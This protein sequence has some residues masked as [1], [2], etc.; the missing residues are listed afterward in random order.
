MT[1]S[2]EP[3]A[4]TAASAAGGGIADGSIADAVAPLRP[5]DWQVVAWRSFLRAHAHLISQLA[6]DLQ[7]HH[8]ISLASYDV[9][10][11]LAEAPDNRL[12]M[13]ELADAVLLSRS[14][15]TRL[16][17]RLQHDEL[18]V[19]E[20]DPGD[21]RGLF[22]VLTTAGRDALREA[23]AVHLAGVQAKFVGRLTDE[24]LR[25]LHALMA[26]IDQPDGADG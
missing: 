1:T 25:Q 10:V 16:V 8:E 18:V 24:E 26:K 12:R 15:L 21:A 9:L 3:D 4:T 13:S 6:Q 2:A 11:Q 7:D 5:G 20:R 23:S 22:T 14:G 17:D 19:R